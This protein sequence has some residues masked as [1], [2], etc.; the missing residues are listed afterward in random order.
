MAHLRGVRQVCY[1][2]TSMDTIIHLKHYSHLLRY[3][4]K[5]VGI[6]MRSDIYKGYCKWLK[7]LRCSADTCTCKSKESYKVIQSNYTVTYTMYHDKVQKVIMTNHYTNLKVAACV[8]S[9]ME[10]FTTSQNDSNKRKK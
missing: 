5:F 8:R 9:L 1:H 2:Y 4:I 7:A 3:K 10:T 6:P